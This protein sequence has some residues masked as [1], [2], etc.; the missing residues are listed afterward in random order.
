MLPQCFE[1]GTKPIKIRM[2]KGLEFS[3]LF[4]DQHYLAIATEMS[5]AERKALA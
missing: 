2:Q 4:C 1:K 3:A 5:E